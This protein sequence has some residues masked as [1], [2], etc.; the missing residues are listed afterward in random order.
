MP[1]VLQ[2]MLIEL[3]KSLQ[4][5]DVDH[6]FYTKIWALLVLGMSLSGR[7]CPMTCLPEEF[8]LVNQ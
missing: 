5:Q 1:D 6:S 8:I 7:Y 4:K 3:C 2:V